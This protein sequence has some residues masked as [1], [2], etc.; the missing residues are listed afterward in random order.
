[1]S[2]LPDPAAAMGIR[3]A[4]GVTVA[5]PSRVDLM[6]PYVLLEQE[7]WFEDEIAFLCRR[8]GAGSQVVDIGANYGLYALSLAEI[9]GAAGRVWA[10]EPASGTAAFLRQSVAIN[11][12]D[13]MTVIQ[14]ALSDRE[15]T[16]RL[17]TEG[18]SELNSLSGGGAGED[19][20]LSTLDHLAA[21]H[22]WA[23]IDF[24]KI[25]AEGEEERILDGGA[26][27]LRSA[28]PLVMFEI[29]HGERINLH[30]V[31]KFAA[32]G[33]RSYQLVP[34]PGVLVPFDPA[35]APDPFRLNLFACKPA[36]AA[37]LERQGWL[38]REPAPLPS[39]GD[40]IAHFRAAHD[41]GAGA[42]ARHAHLRAALA[43]ASAMAPGDDPYALATCARIARELG[44][45]RRAID[46][47]EQGLGRCGHRDPGGP[48]GPALAAIAG[49]DALEPK[50]RPSEWL[51]ASLLDALVTHSAYSTYFA[52]GPLQAATLERLES[53]RT[54]GFQRPPMERRRQL[55]RILA[56]HQ[57]GPEP[58]ACLAAYG[59]D[60]LNPELWGGSAPG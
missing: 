30:L 24:L 4:A 16:A 39:G 42:A 41:E 44:E 7:N 19:V 46:F 51:R 25:D 53:L 3:V 6:T 38:A 10:I 33:Y 15:G 59:P 11:A 50:G 55:M 29:K 49:F 5:V 43:A 2:A 57:A 56:R 22:D 12:L 31:D 40:A 14:N 32:L 13:H 54:S 20:A 17:S 18:N 8:L 34:G 60:N 35:I 37:C 9:A 58:A 26:A 21:S 1:M 23:A 27:F 36:R 47:I 28:D 52:R 48:R 45:R